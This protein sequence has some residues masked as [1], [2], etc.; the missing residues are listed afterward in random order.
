MLAA[1]EVVAIN[2]VSI[3]LNKGSGPHW[4]VIARINEYTDQTGVKAEDRSGG[5]RLYSIEYGSDADVSVVSDTAAA[6]NV[7]PVLARHC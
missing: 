4:R 5:T 3:T 2:G 1:D 6:G 7:P